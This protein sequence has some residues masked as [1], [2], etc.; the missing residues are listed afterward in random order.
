MDQQAYSKQ[1]AFSLIKRYD[2]MVEDYLLDWAE[3]QP[4][5]SWLYGDIANGYASFVVSDLYS[6]GLEDTGL[7]EALTNEAIQAEQNYRNRKNPS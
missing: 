7:W 4:I 6:D 3:E 1:V 2:Q 5:E